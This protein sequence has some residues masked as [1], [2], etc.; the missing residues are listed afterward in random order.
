MSAVLRT[1][2]ERLTEPRLARL[3]PRD[4][5]RQ[6]APHDRLRAER[7]AERHTLVRPPEQARSGEQTT[8]R[9]HGILQT[10]FDHGP[11]RACAL[12]DDHP[13]LVVLPALQFEGAPGGPVNVRSCSG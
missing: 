8:V 7:L 1:H 5:L 2:V 11:L 12:R 6:L 9:A 13:S 4:H 3:C 10:L